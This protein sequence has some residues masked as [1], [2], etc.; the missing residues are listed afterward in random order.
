MVFYFGFQAYNSN[1]SFYIINEYGLGTS[2]EAGIC[3]S[4]YGIGGIIVG[5][6]YPVFQNI[7]KK[8]MVT[9]GYLMNLLALF[10][11]TIGTKQLIFIY[12]AAFLAGVGINMSA[13]FIYAAAASLCSKEMSN[14]SMSIVFVFI[15]I[16]QYFAI[17]ILAETG[18]LLG[19]VDDV[20]HRIYAGILFLI[21]ACI[22]SAVIF[23]G[24][25]Y[26][27]ALRKMG[28]NT[29]EEK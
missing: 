20:L 3:G 15:N 23:I 2:R 12:T 7:F 24:P 6:T 5:F 13:N 19:G 25:F 17:R 22:G 4:L 8:Y 28:N 16:G 18:L 29:I 14:Y 11:M 1:Y 27:H 21:I 10:I 26:Q 9:A